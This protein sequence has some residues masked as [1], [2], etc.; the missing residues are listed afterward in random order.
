MFQ[1]AVELNN[2]KDLFKQ[3]TGI[4]VIKSNVMNGVEINCNVQLQ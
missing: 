2:N 3:H 1:Y 4:P